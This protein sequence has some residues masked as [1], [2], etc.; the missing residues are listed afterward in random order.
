MQARRGGAVQDVG[1]HGPDHLPLL[2]TVARGD[3]VNHR[4]VGGADA[5]GVV[6]RDHRPVHDD[7]GERHHA[8]GRRHHGTLAGDVDAT[9]ARPP[10]HGGIVERCHHVAVDR[11][12]VGERSPR[13]IPLV[14]RRR[15]HVVERR[16]TIGRA[17][18]DRRHHQ[19]DA[20]GGHSEDRARPAHGSAPRPS[21]SIA[22]AQRTTTI[23]G[24]GQH[25]CCGRRCIGRTLWTSALASAHGSRGSAG[26]SA[27]RWHRGEESRGG[28]ATRGKSLGVGYDRSRSRSA[29]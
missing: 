21:S 28:R 17:R 8:V 19:R 9:M 22:P 6:D 14:G 13:T 29:G 11:H 4:F 20:H 15:G 10:R 5:V 16:S 23:A 27:V 12:R 7:A 25:P 1:C 26:G 2:D 3:G 18:D 24:G